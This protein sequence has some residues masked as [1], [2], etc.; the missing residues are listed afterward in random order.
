MLLASTGGML[1]HILQCPGQ[2][3]TAK[4][5]AVQMPLALRLRNPHNPLPAACRW[6][7][8]PY[9]PSYSTVPRLPDHSHQCTHKL[10]L[11]SL[12]KKTNFTPPPPP[13]T[14]SAAASVQLSHT[15]LHQ[16]NS[17]LLSK[18]TLSEAPLRPGFRSSSTNSAHGLSVFP[19]A[20][21]TF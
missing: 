12:K 5:D 17:K 6:A 3:P 7:H 19:T 15:F 21:I 11:P 2:R 14:A 4:S 1:L 20:F 10:C 13:A 9:I 18:S 8:G 16:S